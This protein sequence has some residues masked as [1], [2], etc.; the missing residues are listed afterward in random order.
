[1]FRAESAQDTTEAMATAEKT[2]RPKQD[3]N[4]IHVFIGMSLLRPEILSMV[5]PLTGKA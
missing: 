1:M 5:C 3:H 4:R 2:V